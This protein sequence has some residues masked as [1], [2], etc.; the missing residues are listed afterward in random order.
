MSRLPFLVLL[1]LPAAAAAQVEHRHDVHVHGTAQATLVVDAASLAFELSVPGM[2]AI[3]FEHAP[4]DDAERARLDAALA[5]LEDSGRWLAFE[6]AGACTATTAEARGQGYQAAPEDAAP[7]N[8]RH[9]HD[10]DRD[11]GHGHGSDAAATHGHGELHLSLAGTC[12]T[13]PSHAVVSLGS[14]FGGL[15]VLRVDLIAGDRQDRVELPRGNG[16]IDL[17]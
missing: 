16:R 10:H 7:A 9:D 5:A 2:D 17:R 3:G 6:P 11:H 15:G 8:G 14:L 13:P 4:R 1:A 12:R